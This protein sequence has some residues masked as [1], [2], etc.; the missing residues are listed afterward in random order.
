MTHPADTAATEP[1]VP[2]PALAKSFDALGK[3]LCAVAA[4]VAADPAFAAALQQ[5]P[6][7]ALA[8]A[9]LTLPPGWEPRLPTV[10]ADASLSDE[11]LE[12]VTGGAQYSLQVY[13]TSQ[14]NSGFVLFQQP[15]ASSSGL[16]LAW[17]ANPAKPSTQNSFNWTIDYSFV[18]SESGLLSSPFK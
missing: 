6:V 13:N 4:R 10:E 15:P 16:N 17:F 9:G 5:D 8:A 3:S 1:C 11:A 7:A 2:D 18:W 14:P 12:S